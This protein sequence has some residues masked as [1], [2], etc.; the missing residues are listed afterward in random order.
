MFG[1]I[2]NFF[3]QGSKP[4]CWSRDRIVDPGEVKKNEEKVN[5]SMVPK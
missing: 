2:Q 1:F 4:S 5:P 3:G